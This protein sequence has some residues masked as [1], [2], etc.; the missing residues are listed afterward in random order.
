MEGRLKYYKIDSDALWMLTLIED[1]G[2]CGKIIRELVEYDAGAREKHTNYTQLTDEEGKPRLKRQDAQ[3]ANRV[4]ERLFSCV[5]DSRAALQQ[6]IDAGGKGGKTTQRKKREAARGSYKAENQSTASSSGIGTASSNEEAPLQANHIHNQN[7][8]T[9][10]PFLNESV[11]DSIKAHTRNPECFF[12]DLEGEA[13]TEG[14][15]KE[16]GKLYNLPDKIAGQL[17]RLWEEVKQEMKDKGLVDAYIFRNYQQM[18]FY[19]CIAKAYSKAEKGYA[20]YYWKMANELESKKY[21]IAPA[22]QYGMAL[23]TFIENGKL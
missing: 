10:H 21:S 20:A 6:K 9:Q 4:A 16:F 5:D 8:N 12:E 22:Q 13:K 15:A 7:K 2:V 23:I 1:E 18:H 19:E 14:Y 3:I 11:C 17:P